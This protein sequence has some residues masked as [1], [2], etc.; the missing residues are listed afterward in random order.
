MSRQ[1]PAGSSIMTVAEL[2]EKLENVNPYLVVRVWDTQQRSFTDR[3]DNIVVNHLVILS[4]F[5]LRAIR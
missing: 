5:N 2:I 4:L 3:F 1:R